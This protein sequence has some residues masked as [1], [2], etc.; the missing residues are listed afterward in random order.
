MNTESG[1]AF[2]AVNVI[3]IGKKVVDNG[4]STT[5]YRDVRHDMEGLVVGWSYPRRVCMDLYFL[6]RDVL[7]G[8][9][10]NFRVFPVT[11][12]SDALCLENHRRAVHRSPTNENFFQPN[13]V[14]IIYYAYV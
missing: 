9:W 12:F 10:I 8:F 7:E 4:V 14:F 2:V 11:N 5:W 1:V 3:R 13:N 6:S